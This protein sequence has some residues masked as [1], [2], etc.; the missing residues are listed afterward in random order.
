MNR[1]SIQRNG[2][3]LI[4]LLLVFSCLPACIIVVEEDDDDDDYYRRRWQ[5]EIIVYSNDTHRPVDLNTY[6]VSF[7]ADDVIS[8]KADCAEFEGRYEVGR[9]S[10]LS[11]QG[12]NT[13]DAA[14]GGSALADL[15][16]QGIQEAQSMEGNAEELTI[17][18]AGSGNMMRLTP[19]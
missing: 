16:I 9:A 11:V 4:T 6:T 2:I 8:G 5:L 19:Y 18:F 14:C 13:N 1:F 10:T 7:Q 12:V 3:R 15:F 17:H